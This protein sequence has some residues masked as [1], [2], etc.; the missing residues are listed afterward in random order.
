MKNIFLLLSLSLA[1]SLSA[2][3]IKDTQTPLPPGAVRFSGYL[4]GYIQNSIEHWNKGVVPYKALVDFFRNGRPFLATGE[5]WGKAVRSGCMFYRYTHDPELKQIL[6]ETVL[7][8]L[9]TQR[10]DGS[11]SCSPP[12]QQPDGPQGDIWERKY[13][14]LGM[15]TY[16]EWVEPNPKV[17]ESLKKQA[18]NIISLV[19][20]A[21]KKEI[22]DLGWS[23]ANVGDDEVS[24]IE[25][26]A[27]L[28]PF[29]RLYKWTGEQRYFDFATY[30]IQSGGTKHYNLFDQAFNN[31]APE[32]MGGH[33]PKS[34]EMLSIF[35]GLAEYYRVTGDKRWMQCLLNMYNN[36]REKEITIVGNG[37]ANHPYHP[38][39]GCEAWDNL[40]VEQTNPDIDRMME[41][42]VGV[43]WLKFCS[44]MLRLT[45][46][47]STIDEIE[48]YIYNGLT[49]AMKPGGDGFSYGNMLNGQKVDPNGWGWHLNGLHVTCCNLNGPMGLAYI[50]FV[51]AMQSPDGLAINLF[52]SG[53][54]AARTPGH[55]PIT[56]DI[57]GDYPVSDDVCLKLSLA[58][59]E[60]FV[61]RV[62][63]PVWSEQT[64]VTVE[65]KSVSVK[66][67][68]YAEIK[69][70]WKDG[71]SV[72]LQFDMRCRIID[73]PRGINPKGNNKIALRRG[74]VV[75]SRDENLD[76]Y[77]DNPVSI[78][79]KNGI[80][81]LEP[82]AGYRMRFCV[83]QTD[84][85][86]FTVTDYASVNNWDGSHICTWLP[87]SNTLTEK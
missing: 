58:K 76:P 86:F 70:K 3:Q 40:A 62:R 26:S 38:N 14:M 79:H 68:S 29:M 63:I 11:I 46:D 4:D 42:C 36:V 78:S 65:G 67:G 20:H 44:Q 74:P 50:P 39:M 49:G 23:A 85:S 69:R 9:S 54:I 19:G 73:G 22:T 6:D 71:E 82:I 56:I 33:Y 32:Q 28:E 48:K 43:T 35:E 15:E 61:L 13:V 24:N 72:K 8:M 41:T 31:V 25:S 64:V 77:Y 10:P 87:K 59:S 21:P 34:Y 37:G 1:I 12:E 80:V 66:P 52:Q 81:S 5:M 45:G 17:L 57:S 60:T 83:P 51:A 30:I 18:D 47:P 7:D 84:G 16:Y 75:L 53:T 55:Q 27:I 2:Q